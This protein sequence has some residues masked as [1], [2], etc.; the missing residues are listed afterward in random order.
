MTI[1][2]MDTDLNSVPTRS[3]HNVMNPV[4]SSCVAAI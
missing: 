3:P 4:R 1:N 2:P